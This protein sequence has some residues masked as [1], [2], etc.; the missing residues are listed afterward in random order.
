MSNRPEFFILDETNGGKVTVHL[1]VNFETGYEVFIENTDWN[2]GKKAEVI[3]NK[4]QLIQLIVVLQDFSTMCKEVGELPD[5]LA[6][7]MQ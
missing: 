1:E 4:D 6:E 5:D 3:L 7:D 2:T